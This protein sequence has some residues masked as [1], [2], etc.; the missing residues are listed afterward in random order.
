M[1]IDFSLDIDVIDPALAPA[2]ELLLQD[3]ENSNLPSHYSCF[4]SL[5]GTPEPAGWTPRELH[6][7]LRGLAG[8][9][10]MYVRS[11]TEAVTGPLA[12]S[13]HVYFGGI[14]LFSS[15][16]RC[17]SFS[18]VD[19]VEVSPA[20][21]TNGKLTIYYCLCMYLFE[22]GFSFLFSLQTSRDYQRNCGEYRPRNDLHAHC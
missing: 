5:A 8:L 19:I 11:V 2:S 17:S 7:I 15:A 3:S 10:F 6:R 9:N 4:M 22:L 20:Y 21:D 13:A 1:W 18:G 14:R 12:H 16:C